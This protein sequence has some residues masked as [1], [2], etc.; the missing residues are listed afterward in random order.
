[1]ALRRR[2]SISI[3]LASC[4]NE[5]WKIPRKLPQSL[6]LTAMQTIDS[7]SRLL[8]YARREHDGEVRGTY[9]L[10]HQ[11]APYLLEESGLAE[12]VPLLLPLQ[13]LPKIFARYGKPLEL[14]PHRVI[15]LPETEAE[16]TLLRVPVAD[17]K[18]A[19]LRRLR[20]LSFGWVEPVDFL[21]WEEAP[22]EPVA[23]EAALVVSA[24]SA[25][26]RATASSFASG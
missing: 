23:V 21:V 12:D 20:Y 22:A 16:R 25:I 4:R 15:E 1:M 13:A 26:A 14:Q 18:S 17:G 3:P 2:P 11:Q 8:L 6:Y 19:L 10:L 24:L 7:Q 5:P 9:L